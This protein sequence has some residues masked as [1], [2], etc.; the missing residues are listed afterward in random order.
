VSISKNNLNSKHLDSLNACERNQ[1]DPFVSTH[2][3]F[4]SYLKGSFINDVTTIGEEGQLLD[5]DKGRGVK[6]CSKLRGVIY[7]RSQ[8]VKV[9]HFLS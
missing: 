6:I 2:L 7:G 8:Q 5:D 9:S 1:S 3:K 4:V